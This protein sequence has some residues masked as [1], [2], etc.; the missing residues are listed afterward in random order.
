MSLSPTVKHTGQESGGE[1]CHIFKF[2]SFQL[3]K[4][5][6]NVCKVLQ[7]LSQ[8]PY[9]GFALGPHWGTLVPNWTSW[10]MK[11]PGVATENVLV[12]LPS[13]TL[14]TINGPSPS[15]LFINQT[16]KGAST[17]YIC[18]PTIINTVKSR[19]YIP[20]LPTITFRVIV[21]LATRTCQCYAVNITYQV[22][23]IIHGHRLRLVRPHAAT[24]RFW[25]HSDCIC[26]HCEMCT[27]TFSANAHGLRES[28]LSI[29]SVE[30]TLTWPHNRK[31]FLLYS[32]VLIRTE[33]QIIK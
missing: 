21:A 6:N 32:E 16:L 3:S 1:L 30:I 9:R 20:I 18:A 15:Y 4:F 27:R 11:I 2:R 24:C 28:K 22:H 17:T 33:P 13:I 25:S 12:G 5:V 10:A 7:L 23:S 31:L 19:L 8:T 29:L 26:L 14:Q